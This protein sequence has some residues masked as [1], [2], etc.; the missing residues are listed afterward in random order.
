MA[1]LTISRESGSGGREIGRAA[2]EALGYEYVDK[3]RILSDIRKLGNKWEQWT[4][5]L[6]E[7][8]PT[9]WEKFDWSFR[10]VGALVQSAL[11]KHALRDKTV[12][13]GRGGNFL[14]EGIPFSLRI[15]IVAPIEVRIARRAQ[16]DSVDQER[17]RWLIEKTDR[18]RSRFIYTLYGRHSDDPSEYDLILNTG[19][20]PVEEAVT[21]IKE[22]LK[23]R[24]R[25]NTD[26]WRKVLEMRALAASI[27]AAL[28]SDPSRFI[29]TL[30]VDYDGAQLVLRGVIHNP[31]EHKG[32]EKAARALAGNVPLKCELHYRQ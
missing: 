28:L 24:D 25:F 18:E 7:H 22:L 15:R 19:F 17:A 30:D 8:S 12:I 29:P 3:E 32:I 16:K 27:K 14:L 6:D 5:E 1:I 4:E 20:K 9:I 26:E 21:L 11:L 31:K 13:I 10:A 23:E 2:A